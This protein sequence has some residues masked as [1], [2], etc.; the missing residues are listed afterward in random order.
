MF[1]AEIMEDLATHILNMLNE[2]GREFPELSNEITTGLA[3]EG[4]IV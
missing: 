2:I 1:D 3:L 4:I